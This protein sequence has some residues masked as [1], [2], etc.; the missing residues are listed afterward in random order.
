MTCPYLEYRDE[1]DDHEFD[2]D[3]PYCAAQESFVSPMR[4]DICN[5]RH[6]FDHREHCEVFKAARERESTT[7]ASAPQQD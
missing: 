3:R 7:M 2:H 6:D 5:D 4:A 1:D